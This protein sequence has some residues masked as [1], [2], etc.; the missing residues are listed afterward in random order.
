LG[1]ELFK[2]ERIPSTGRNIGGWIAPT[3][4][5]GIDLNKTYESKA[6]FI[7]HNDGWRLQEDCRGDIC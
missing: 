1:T 3:E 4:L 2:N 7:L 6:T 5:T